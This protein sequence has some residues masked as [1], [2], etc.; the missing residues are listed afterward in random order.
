MP[1]VVFPLTRS[2]HTYFVHVLDILLCGLGAHQLFDCIRSCM[3][4]V[5][6][7]LSVEGL[8]LSGFDTINNPSV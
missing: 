5:S 4:S 3:F 2:S 8:L 6:L 7:V 1:G